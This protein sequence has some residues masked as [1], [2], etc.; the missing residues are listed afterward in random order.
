[1]PGQ[2]G[3]TTSV[4]WH[5]GNLAV[6]LPPV[7]TYEAGVDLTSQGEAA[8]CVYYLSKGVV[9]LAHMSPDGRV[10]ILELA[11][12][13]DLIGAQSI[14][15][16]AECFE[17]ATTLVNSGLARWRA[18]EFLTKFKAEPAFSME[19]AR[20]LCRQVCRLR[21]CVSEFGVQTA[22]QKFEAL[23]RSWPGD[24]VAGRGNPAGGFDLPLSRDEIGQLLSISQYYVARLLGDL[25]EDRVIRREGREIR[26]LPAALRPLAVQHA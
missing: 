10:S 20:V 17:T 24:V 5:K 26:V 12:A 6:P 9:K 14:F 1:M 7:E 25:E 16:G 23:L 11:F 22:R 2:R 19:V 21:W 15:L 18:P 8:S 3:E 13:G 4:P